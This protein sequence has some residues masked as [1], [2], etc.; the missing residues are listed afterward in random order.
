MNGQKPSLRG[1][2]MLFRGGFSMFFK[3][4][5]HTEIIRHP[6]FSKTVSQ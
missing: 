6:V 4:A 3:C 5:N 1:K 2:A